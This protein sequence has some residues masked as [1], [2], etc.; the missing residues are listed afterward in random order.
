M[1][2]KLGTTIEPHYELVSAEEHGPN[3]PL[4]QHASYDQYSARNSAKRSRRSISLLRWRITAFLSKFRLRGILVPFRST[5]E[6]VHRVQETPIVKDRIAALL[7]SLIHIPAIAGIITLS[8][9]IFNEYYI[10]KELE[11][12]PNYDI[13][14]KL[15]IQFAAK[16]MELFI[17][18]SLTS[19]LFAVIR[20]EFT[21]GEGVPYGALVAGQQ[22]TDI[23][24][25]WSPE[26]MTIVNGKFSRFWKKLAFIF[27]TFIFTILALGASSLSATVMM[28][29]EDDWAAGGSLVWANATY[30]EIF[31]TIL[32]ENNTIGTACN[33]TG[34]SMC[35]SWEWDILNHQ[36]I[37]KLRTSSQIVDGI[38]GPRPPRNVVL[39]GATTLSKM[40]V[41]VREKVFNKNSP[42]HTVVS[43][44]HF[45]GSDSVVL[46][47]LDWE[48]A[49]DAASK[50]GNYRFNMYQKIQHLLTAP[51]P[52]TH[53]RCHRSSMSPDSLTEPSFPDFRSWEYPAIN[54]T[55]DEIDDWMSETLPN[56]EGPE[57]FWFE[58]E[59]SMAANASIGVIVAVP[60]NDDDLSIDV[61]GCMVDARWA[62][63]TITGDAV[64]LLAEGI[65]PFSDALAT[66]L[67]GSW[68][69][70]PTYGRKI[71]IQTGFANYLNPLDPWRNRT[72]IHELL[73]TSG[74]WTAR[75][76]G[77]RSEKHLET[78]LGVLTTNGL[79]RSAPN[80]SAI[81]NLADPDGE[82]WKNFLPQGG[83]VFG[84]GGN[85]YAVTEEEQ[86]TY[87]GTEMETFITG[88]A[89]ADNS[90]TIRSAMAVFYVYIFFVLAFSIWSIWTGVTSSSWESVPELL[91]LSLTGQDNGK[92][93]DEDAFMKENY[94]ITAEGNKLRL[95]TVHGPLPVEDRV[96][97]N[98]TYD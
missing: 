27:I 34:N 73:L 12:P 70:S 53:S 57:V 17:V 72:I 76:S 40:S 81:T 77:S 98:E 39:S 96:K 91:A 79:A 75:G 62:V 56:L 6:W 59:S 94:C 65:P 36:L 63:T 90:L 7:T 55:S 49:S 68:I 60:T 3:A 31:P 42:N 18:L 38:L 89:F 19:I 83:T 61:Y 86:A 35:P 84:R 47:S 41:D 46:S 71:Q 64:S 20:Y 16:L 85:P 43:M 52:I 93:L 69:L 33:I 78:I 50:T 51:Q 87:Y 67:G 8:F 32:S 5:R 30:D 45:V 92:V 4:N 11:G 80:T 97:P 10:G 82:W 22:I 66:S 29:Q 44:P 37:A 74:I 95:R 25:L 21:I 88:F 26:F 23:S 58:P 1:A 48:L 2:D 14:K 54:I 24:F 9:Y 13:Q 15:G 28:P